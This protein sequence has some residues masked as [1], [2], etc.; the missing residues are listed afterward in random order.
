MRKKIL[1]AEQ[2]ETIRNIAESLLR[3][4]GYEVIAISTPDK[5]KELIITAE[6]NMVIIGADLKD[7]DGSYIYELLS[8]NTQTSSLPLLIIADPNGRELSYPDEIILPRPFDPQDFINRVQL[9]VGKV[10]KSEKEETITEADP[11]S[12]ASVDDEFLDAALGIDNIDVESSEMLNS[13]T[14]IQKANQRMQKESEEY[15]MAR[16]EDTKT[17]NDSSRVESLLIRENGDSESIEKKQKS[18]ELSS[19]SKLEI[20]T[21]QYGMSS[22]EKSVPETPAKEKKPHDYDWFIGEMQKGVTGSKSKPTDKDAQPDPHLEKTDNSDGMEPIRGH[23]DVDKTGEKSVSET[24]IISEGGVDK[25]ITEFKKEME[26]INSY[27]DEPAAP[28]DALDESVSEAKD[29]IPDESVP[30]EEPYIGD[31]SITEENPDV[32]YDSAPEDLQEPELTQPEFDD[33]EDEAPIQSESPETV[34]EAQADMQDGNKESLQQFSNELADKV[35]KRIAQNILDKIDK[36]DLD[37]LIKEML[38]Q[39]ISPKK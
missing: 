18:P 34:T 14:G 8:E 16:D 2:S 7:V 26:Q 1:L 37:S 35:A 29:E 36:K 11:L 5:A 33:S 23:E 38:P 6:P 19:S 4:N 24:P 10:H 12:L 21:D 27:S 9:F 32:S 20:Q 25:F 17:E 15:G 13:T 30:D 22:P 31:E 3:Q 39:I 28:A